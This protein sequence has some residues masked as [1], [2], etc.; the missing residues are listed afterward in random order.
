MATEHTFDLLSGRSEVRIPSWTRRKKRNDRS[1]TRDRSF[2]FFCSVP[3]S[4]ASGMLLPANIYS[5]KKNAA[6]D[7]DCMHTVDDTDLER[8]GNRH[9]PHGNQC[10]C[11]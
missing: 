10:Y 6:I 11:I 7:V 9:N 3:N 1:L 2:R 5:K 4:F 8:T